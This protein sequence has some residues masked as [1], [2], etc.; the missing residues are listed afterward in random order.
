MLSAIVF[1]R[2]AKARHCSSCGEMSQP[3][4]FVTIGC[5]MAVL[6]RSF[7]PAERRPPLPPAETEDVKSLPWRVMS[8]T[9]AGS[10]RRSRPYRW[11]LGRRWQARLIKTRNAP[12]T[13]TQQNHGR[14]NRAADT[15][16]RGTVTGYW[17]RFRPNYWQIL[18]G[19]YIHTPRYG[20]H[21]GCPCVQ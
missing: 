20:S 15:N 21:T 14:L 7:V 9:P 18:T 11:L 4:R 8:R 3:L 16:S 6:L 17:F 13:Q 5:S 1:H 10:R 2:A 19:G 12:S